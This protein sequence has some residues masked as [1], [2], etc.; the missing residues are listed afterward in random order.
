MRNIT[1]P[2]NPGP[3]GALEER[4][5]SDSSTREGGLPATREGAGARSPTAVPKGFEPCCSRL[6]YKLHSEQ[7]D[8]TW[9]RMVS[10]TGC[11]DHHGSRDVWT[12]GG[13]HLR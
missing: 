13:H 7:Q 3:L 1:A 12:L 5:T 4:T 2:A 11:M 9:L 10:E 6:G 8:A